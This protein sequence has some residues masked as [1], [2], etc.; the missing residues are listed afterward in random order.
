MKIG[1]TVRSESDYYFV[2]K[3][4]LKYFADCEIVIIYP[5]ISACAYAGVDGFVI[6]GGADVNPKL[7]NEENYLSHGIDDEIDALDIEIIRY[8][9]QN[10]KPLFGICRG[11]QIINIYFKGT[12]K[13]H[14]FNH[15]NGSHKL[16]LVENFL[17]FP[18]SVVVNS[19][20]HQ[21]V[22]KLGENLKVLYYSLDGEVEVFVHEKL[23]ILAVQF[24]PEMDINNEFS[25]LLRDYFFSLLNM[26]KWVFLLSK[27]I[28]NIL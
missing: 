9:A 13:Q 18:S 20:H 1:I 17:N 22:K 10:N 2:K 8:A 26:Y 16:I 24:H 6:I 15:E 25:T 14:I 4:Y 27:I 7:Y 5:Y 28:G 12:L 11:L 21:S 23:P 19:F 3:R